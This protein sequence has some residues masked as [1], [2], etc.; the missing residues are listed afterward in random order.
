MKLYQS[1][2]NRKEQEALGN[3]YATNRVNEEVIEFADGE[4]NDEEHVELQDF[5]SEDR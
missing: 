1:Q 3:T 5:P 4:D 2:Q